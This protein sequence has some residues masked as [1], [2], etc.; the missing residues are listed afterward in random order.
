LRLVILSGTVAQI[1]F[2]ALPIAAIALAAERSG[3]VHDAAIIVTA[4]AIGGLVGAV[5]STARRWTRLTPALVMGGGFAVIGLITL[6]AVPDLGMPWTVIVIGLSGVLNASSSAA[7]L[8]LRKVNSPAE[9]RS[10]VFTIGSGLRSASAALGAAVA[11]ALAGL[12]AGWLIAGIGAVW[13]LGGLVMAGYR[14]PEA[15]SL[16]APIGSSSAR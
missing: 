15:G 10:Q 9:L 3:D 6:L 2:G 7:M 12:D 13:V 11:G 4:F 8:L 16:E 5:A 1:G 14:P